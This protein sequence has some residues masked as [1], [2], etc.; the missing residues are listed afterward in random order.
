M[1]MDSEFIDMF[2]LLRKIS[3]KKPTVLF[4]RHAE[5]DKDSN[6]RDVLRGLTLKGKRDALLLGKEMARLLPNKIVNIYY[7]PV[8]RC[9]VTARQIALGAD[10]NSAYVQ[11][12]KRL[13]GYPDFIIDR[14]AKELAIKEN[15]GKFRGIIDEVAAG[16]HNK[17]QNFFSFKLGARAL[18]EYSLANAKHGVTVNISHDWVIYYLARYI[19]KATGKFDTERPRYLEILSLQRDDRDRIVANYS[20]NIR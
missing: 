10:I 1:F 3:F 17:Y 18:C 4:I 16:Q 20:K 2:E 19:G 9:K 12:C 7:S 13:E 11:E 15:G 8:G 14:D 5:K 6:K